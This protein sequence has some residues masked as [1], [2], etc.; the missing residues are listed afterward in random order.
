M[1]D[2]TFRTVQTILEQ[3]LACDPDD[4]TAG[5][6]LVADLGAESIDFLDITFRLERSFGLPPLTPEQLFPVDVFHGD[7]S[8]VHEGL[9]TAKGIGLLKAAAPWA[10][11]GT[12]EQA[13]ELASVTDI[14]TVGALVRRV[15]ELVRTAAP[16]GAAR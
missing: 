5:A 8:C 4:I 15:Q 1:H 12:W 13:P 3:A 16:A 2:E 9:V 6:R 14:F 11:F 7:A 10:D